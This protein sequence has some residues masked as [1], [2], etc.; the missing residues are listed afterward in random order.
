MMASHFL[1]IKTI[2]NTRSNLWNWIELQAWRSVGLGVDTVAA[3]GCNEDFDAADAHNEGCIAAGG[4]YDEHPVEG[5][6]GNVA[7]GVDTAIQCAA[8]AVGDNIAVAEESGEPEQLV[9]VAMDD[10]QTAAEVDWLEDIVV[11]AVDN[12]LAVVL[13]AQQQ[14]VLQIDVV[15]T[16]LKSSNWRRPTERKTKPRHI[17][18][19]WNDV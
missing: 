13:G 7:A 5:L 1:V 19:S 16:N 4:N 15:S 10:T 8:A 3:V 11:V 6:A 9:V 18:D 17:S 12:G 2:K 14:Q